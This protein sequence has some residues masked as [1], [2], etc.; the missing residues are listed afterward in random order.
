MSFSTAPQNLAGQIGGGGTCPGRSGLPSRPAASRWA[1]SQICHRRG[2]R[3]QPPVVG[4]GL[5]QE[6]LEGIVEEGSAP[7][8]GRRWGESEDIELHVGVSFSSESPRYSLA[9]CS[10]QP[11]EIR[12]AVMASA[13]QQSP[14]E[15]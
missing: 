3:S 14:A 15:K 10:S 8:V 1:G 13:P 2:E 11:A 6:S 7:T 12:G 4:L 9:K 5:F